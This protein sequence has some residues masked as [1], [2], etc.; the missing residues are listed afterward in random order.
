MRVHV[1]AE[2]PS[3]NAQA[4]AYAEYR[5]FSA[6]S[7]YGSLI[8]GAQVVLRYEGDE[9]PRAF[10]C[11]MTVSLEPDGVVRASVGAS[12]AYAAIDQAAERIGHLI[13][14]RTD[15]RAVNASRRSRYAAGQDR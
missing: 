12:Y 10:R 2:C 6:L 4:Q 13:R 3:N 8:Q 5:L 11:Q 7:Q 14:R 1:L 15:S 9:G